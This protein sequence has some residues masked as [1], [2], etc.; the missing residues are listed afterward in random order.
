MKIYNKITNSAKTYCATKLVLFGSRARN[1]NRENSDIDIAVF[2]MPCENRGKFW[3]EIEELETLLDVDIVHVSSGTDKA[4]LINI[5]KDG[6]VLMD[7]FT[8]KLNKLKDATSRL[9]EAV[10]E[11]T[12]TGSDVVRD[13]AIQRFE[14]CTELAWKTIREKLLDEGITDINSPKSVLRKAYANNIIKDEEKWINLISDRNSTSHIYD[15][16]TAVQIYENIE[17]SY[18][19]LFRELIEILE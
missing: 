11:H 5:E 7:K 19:I 16:V 8:E 12:A 15:E 4:L 10:S 13:G 1:D 17:K 14:F 3:L 9:N 2:G 18:L 6:I